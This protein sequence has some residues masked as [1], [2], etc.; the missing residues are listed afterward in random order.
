M[1]SGTV[2]R[3]LRSRKSGRCQAPP[4]KRGALSLINGTGASSPE[5]LVLQWIE[6]GGHNV[7]DKTTF[8]TPSD[9]AAALRFAQVHVSQM[10]VSEWTVLYLR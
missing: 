10:S 6:R 8:E 9:P 7:S 3:R 5:L 1:P 4:L 2:W